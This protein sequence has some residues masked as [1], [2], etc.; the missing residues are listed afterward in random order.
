M[1]NFSVNDKIMCFLPDLDT[2]Y[3]MIIDPMTLPKLDL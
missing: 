2:I 1:P 3:T